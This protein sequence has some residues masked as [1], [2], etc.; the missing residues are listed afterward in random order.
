MDDATSELTS[1]FFVDEEGTQSS[2]KGI[3][4]TI[5]KKRLFCSFYTDRGS[6][7]FHTP[8]A[9]AK[10]SKTQLTHV[11]AVLKRLGIQHMEVI[12]HDTYLTITH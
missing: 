3:E 9:G 5:L 10:V 7:Y 6:H 2:L 4:E 1:A 8:K 11:G 12:Q